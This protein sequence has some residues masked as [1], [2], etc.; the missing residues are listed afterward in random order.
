MEESATRQ[1]RELLRIGDMESARKVVDCGIEQ[2]EDDVNTSELWRLRFMRAQILSLRGRSEEALQFLESLTPPDINDAES[3]AELKR[4]RGAYS[5]YLGR[6]E[7]AHRLFEE[8]EII[9]RGADLFEILGDIYLS[10]A[11]IVFRQKDYAASDSLFRAA[12]E[13]S[14]KVGG[15]YLRGNGLWG[16]GKNLMIREH[17]T[18]GIPWLEQSLAIFEEA[19]SRLEVAMVWSELAVCYLGLGDDERALELFQK[20]EKVNHECGAAHNYQIVLANI[21]NV[22]LHR[23]EYF[24]AISYYRRALGSAREINDAVSIKKWTRNIKLAY[25]RI[26]AE[27]D[28][29]HPRTA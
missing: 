29:G 4:N 18:E 25:A 1:A 14:D 26:R 28:C 6:Y 21:G 11:F 9:A 12:L 10:R 24:T 19:G 8:A 15:W 16:I 23:R 17:Y 3:T 27:V 22:Y 13:L 2:F 5:G 20:A 7:V